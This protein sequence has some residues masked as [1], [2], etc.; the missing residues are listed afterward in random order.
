VEEAAGAEDVRVVGWRIPPTDDAHL[1]AQARGTMPRIV[2]AVLE[3][4]RPDERAAYRLRRR[5]ERA[6][7]GTYV[8]S[9]SFRT[10]LYKG[11]VN[12]NVLSGFYPDLADESVAA[13]FA[14]FHPRFPPNPL[15]TS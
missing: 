3:S 1:G 13:P 2:Q 7:S 15:P 10:V 5:I 8:A 6:T 12:A 9:C 11:L 14:V 4:D